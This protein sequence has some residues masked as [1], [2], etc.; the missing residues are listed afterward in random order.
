MYT[1]AQ[2]LV[3]PGSVAHLWTFKIANCEPSR[4]TR[5]P[6]FKILI[7]RSV[8]AGCC[9][10]ILSVSHCPSSSL[11]LYVAA[12]DNSSRTSSSCFDGHR[13]CISVWTCVYH[14][15]RPPTVGSTNEHIRNTMKGAITWVLRRG[16]DDDTNPYFLGCS[17]AAV[18]QNQRFTLRHL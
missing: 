16:Q 4:S 8:V 2:T 5:T 7:L 11:L 14:I 17:K 10:C 13:R 12:R 1:T 3:R 15:P 18:Q 6:R 9:C